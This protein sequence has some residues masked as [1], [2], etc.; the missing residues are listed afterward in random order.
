VK[1]NIPVQLATAHD[2]PMGIGQLA[3]LSFS[4]ALLIADYSFRVFTQIQVRLESS[5][6]PKHEAPT[7]AGYVARQYRHGIGV[8]W[9]EFASMQV[10]YL[11]RAISDDP[12]GYIRQS[13]TPNY[14]LISRNPCVGHPVPVKSRIGDGL[15]GPCL[16][17]D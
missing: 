15:K 1:V 13:E 11:L 7:I 10:T 2:S 16:N 6:L 12:D 17:R 14:I 3:N 9:C 5:L 4:G 8:E